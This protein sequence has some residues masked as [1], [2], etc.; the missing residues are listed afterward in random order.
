[1]RGDVRGGRFVA[2]FSGEQFALPAAIRTLRRVRKQKDPVA[3]EVDACDPLN[4]VGI[5]TP[6]ERV[7]SSSSEKVTL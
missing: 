2:G 5:V 6:S 3:I 4:L 1:L 7:P